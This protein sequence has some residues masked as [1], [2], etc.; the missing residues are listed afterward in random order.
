M[1]D[2]EASY[3]DKMLNEALDMDIEREIERRIK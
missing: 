1:Q 2:V 3:V